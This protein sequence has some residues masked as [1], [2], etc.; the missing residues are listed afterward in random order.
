M[1]S[2]VGEIESSLE[3]RNPVLLSGEVHGLCTS[4]IARYLDDM[5]KDVVKNEMFPEHQL[6]R[7]CGIAYRKGEPPAIVEALRYESKF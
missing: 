1:P 7:D 6:E 3:D 5:G 2:D 4:D